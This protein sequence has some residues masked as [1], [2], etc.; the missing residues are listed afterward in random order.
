MS[1]LWMNSPVGP[2]TAFEDS[3]A[4]VALNWGRPPEPR[5]TPLLKAVV[6]QLEA[7]FG[8]R[9]KCFDLPLDPVGTPFQKSVWDRMRAI[10]FG[11]VRTYG[12]LA[13]ELGSAPRAVGGASARNP[14]A[15]II[16]CHRI[17]AADGKLTG[18]SGGQG[19]LTKR[20]LLRLEGVAGI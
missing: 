16:P 14:I 1:Y 18:Y 5:E 15:I 9:L 7:Y 2:L 13:A 4:L 10:P 3:G 20:S 6:E 17:I 12:A 19:L 8:G 11:E